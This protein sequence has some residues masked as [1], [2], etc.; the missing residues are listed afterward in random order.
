MSDRK[1]SEVYTVYKA[2][3]VDDDDRRYAYAVSFLPQY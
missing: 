2:T 1:G 3:M